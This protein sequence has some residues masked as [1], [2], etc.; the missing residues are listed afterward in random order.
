MASRHREREGMPPY[1]YEFDYCSLTGEDPEN[2][3]QAREATGKLL[4]M[5]ATKLVRMVKMIFDQAA[6]FFD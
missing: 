1:P 5:N 4:E 6:E 2:D 3:P